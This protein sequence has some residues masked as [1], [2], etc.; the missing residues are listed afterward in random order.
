[1]RFSFSLPSRIEFGEGVSS[2]VGGEVADLGGKRVLVVTDRGVRAAGLVEPVVTKLAE[3][4]LITTVFDDVAGNPRDTNVAAGASLASEEGCDVIV[5]VGGGSAIDCAKGIAAV[6]TYGGTI[7]DY[8]S[9][10]DDWFRVPGPVT[11]LVAIP[12]TAGTG[13]EVTFWAVITD[14]ARSHKMG[15]G[16]PN[17]APRVALVDPGVTLSLPPSMTA[18]TGM[19]ALTHAVEAYTAR[20]AQPISDALALAAIDLIA[21]NLRPAYADGQN[22]EARHNMMLAS[23]LAGVA[24]A[25][26]DVAG[27]HAMGETIGGF[28]D[29]PHGVAMAIYLPVIMEFNAIA[30]PRKFAEIARRMGERVDTLSPMEAARRAAQAVGQLAADLDIPTARAAGVRDEDLEKLAERAASNLS[31]PDNARTATEKDYLSLFE[32][33]QSA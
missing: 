14:T 12:T 2:A 15:V 23:L 1:M 18:A 26:S 33:A 31:A 11:P 28:Y 9:Q 24:F 27:V 6:H 29:T 21:N 8:E 4:D 13:A 7:Q 17:L 32:V 30:A 3:S 22:L 10:P 19:D 16:D 20:C 5:A 25:N